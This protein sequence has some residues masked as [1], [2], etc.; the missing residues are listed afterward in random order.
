M[1][2]QIFIASAATVAAVCLAAYFALR[3]ERKKKALEIRTTQLDRI[4]ELVNR[5]STNLMQYTGTLA[6]ILEA[7]AK[8]NY[9]P[10]KKFDINV[11]S[12]W[13][14]CLDESEVWAIDRQ[15][16]RTCQHSLEFHREKEW[17]E[18]KK[19]I[20]PLLDKI[21]Q[22]FLISKPGQPVTFINGQNKTADEL[23]VFSRYLRKQT[24]EIESV[25]QLL[26]SQMR[27]EFIELTSFEPVTMFSLFKSI[28]KNVMQFFCISALKN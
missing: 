13:K 5:A 26:L 17:A 3:N 15:Q 11:I 20:P 18:W 27:E 19:I 7:H 21:D 25:R 24:A 23:L 2:M 1:N 28:K 6:S 14:D 8:D 4:S 22:F 10:N 16:L 12:K 9:L